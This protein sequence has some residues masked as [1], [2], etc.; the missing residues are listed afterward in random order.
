VFGSTSELQGGMGAT[1]EKGRAGEWQ[2]GDPIVFSSASMAGVSQE[3]RGLD[4]G[5]HAASLATRTLSH[6]FTLTSGWS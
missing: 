6:V 3:R 4:A 1:G 5:L 2:S